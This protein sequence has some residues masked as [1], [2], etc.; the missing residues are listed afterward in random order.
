M[1]DPAPLT[2]KQK[3]AWACVVALC[4]VTLVVLWIAA[5]RI[6]A[7]KLEARKGTAPAYDADG[8]A[9]IRLA[10]VDVPKARYAHFDIA[11]VDA[12]RIRVSRTDG[13]PCAEFFALRDGEVRRWQELQLTFAEVTDKTLRL[14]AELK[15]GAP[16]YGE[17]LYFDLRPGLRIELS[18]NCSVTVLEISRESRT[19]RLELQSPDTKE[20]ISIAAKDKEL[21]YRGFPLHLLL[22]LDDALGLRIAGAW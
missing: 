5:N 7:A 8:S 19:V 3:I 16:C 6:K 15:P 12:G 17:G 4:A 22:S 18:G 14:K 9:L 1:P 10:P 11:L 13:T 2:P 20:T 21:P